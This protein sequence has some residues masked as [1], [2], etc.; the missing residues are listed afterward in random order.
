LLHRLL[1]QIEVG[2]KQIKMEVRPLEVEANQLEAVPGTQFIVVV[3]I[4]DF[5]L[6]QLGLRLNH[7]M[8]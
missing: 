5:M 3:H 6:F 8:P 1:S 7:P 4:P 2:V